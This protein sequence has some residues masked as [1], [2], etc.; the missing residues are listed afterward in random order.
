MPSIPFDNLPSITPIDSVPAPVVSLPREP[1]SRRSFDRHLER[2]AAKPTQR[3]TEVAPKNE[4][5]DPESNSPSETASASPESPPVQGQED[6]RHEPEKDPQVKSESDSDAG[7]P[8]DNADPSEQTQEQSTAAAE[9]SAATVLEEA[10]IAQ[11]TTTTEDAVALDAEKEGPIRAR[12]TLGALSTEK[13]TMDGPTDAQSKPAAEQ[14]QAD[15]VQPETI[16]REASVTEQDARASDEDARASNEDARVREAG[17]RRGEIDPRKNEA[18]AEKTDHR[19]VDPGAAD[20]AATAAIEKSTEQA[21]QAALPGA[22]AGRAD[23]KT[24]KVRRGIP[25]GAVQ[26][27]NKSAGNTTAAAMLETIATEAASAN[28]TRREADAVDPAAD[29]V[30]RPGANAN[31]AAPANSQP[32]LPLHLAS[33]S[34]APSEG[35]LQLTNADQVRFIQRV[36]RAFQAAGARDGTIRLRLSPPELGSMRLEVTVQGGVMTAQIQVETAAARALLVDNLGALRERLAEQ[37]IKVEQ[38]D[39]DLTDRQTGGLPDGPAGKQDSEDDSAQNA[40]SAPQEAEEADGTG[41][42]QSETL[43]N[44]DG[45]LNVVI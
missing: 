3:E 34:G 10:V 18:K 23:A 26:A 24:T 41:S 14:A 32:R 1:A 31:G 33:R 19:P 35:R 16:G 6:G 30:A 8:A 42:S 22:T 27:E 9:V 44:E 25:T 7:A 37:G 43:S 20:R 13:N 36:A 29:H 17:I 5:E 15:D 40:A 12:E 11:E 2:P 39:I 28:N 21:G 4:S 45:R 38:F